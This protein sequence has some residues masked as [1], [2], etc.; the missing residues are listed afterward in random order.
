MICHFFG[1]AT[2]LVI[3]KVDYIQ[4]DTKDAKS[5]M[6]IANEKQRKEEKHGW[7]S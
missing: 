6:L 1:K 2:G 5:K 7:R 3:L 4:T